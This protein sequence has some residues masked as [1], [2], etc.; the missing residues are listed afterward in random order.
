MG[1]DGI[2]EVA[3]SRQGHPFQYTNGVAFV[4]LKIAR[5]SSSGALICPSTRCC[6]PQGAFHEQHLA[7]MYVLQDFLPPTGEYQSTLVDGK[8]MCHRSPPA[9]PVTIADTYPYI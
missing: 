8:E 4:L 2:L 6:P 9:T 7:A 5:A 1:G 3:P